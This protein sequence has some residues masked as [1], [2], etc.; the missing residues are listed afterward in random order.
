MAQYALRLSPTS[1]VQNQAAAWVYLHAGQYER[2]EAQARRTLELFPE[3][4]QPQFVLGWAAW[5]QGKAD[6]AVEVFERALAV[7][8]EAL[9]LAFLGHVYGRLGRA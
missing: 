2:A 9:S 5:R 8:R 7:S 4:L 1:L 3:S 6:A